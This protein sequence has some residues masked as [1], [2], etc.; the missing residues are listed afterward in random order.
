MKSCFQTQ[1][2]RGHYI[3]SHYDRNLCRN[4]FEIQIM[5]PDGSFTLYSAKSLHSAKYKITRIT[6]GS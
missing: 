6:G 2:Y 3:H 5:R 1:S 4:V